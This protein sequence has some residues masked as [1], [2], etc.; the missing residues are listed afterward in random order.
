M[1]EGMCVYQTTV[2]TTLRSRGIGENK[3]KDT[4]PWTG[5][6]FPQQQKKP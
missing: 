6:H 2:V 4:K 3:Q 5:I 1:K